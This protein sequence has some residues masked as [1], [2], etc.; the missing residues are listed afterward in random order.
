MRSP[1]RR[2]PSSSGARLRSNP[3]RRG[4]MEVASVATGEWAFDDDVLAHSVSDLLKEYEELM[5]G[6]PLR[7]ARVFVSPFPQAAPAQSWS[8]ETRGGT[9]V[10]LSGRL[11]SKTF[12]LSRLDGILAHEL[13]HLWVPNG[14]SLDGEYDWFYV[15]LH[16]ITGLRRGC[17]GTN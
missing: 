5:G 17:G 2:C 3:S 1:T 13:L 11:P 15:R 8:A 14:L 10:I 7:R 9:V 6:V 4:G 16:A 12:A